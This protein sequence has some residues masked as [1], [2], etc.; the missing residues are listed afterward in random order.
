[1][2]TK[3]EKNTGGAKH[4]Y[5]RLKHVAAIDV[6]CYANLRSTLVMLID[7]Y[8]TVLDNMEKNKEKLAY[9]KGTNGGGSNLSMY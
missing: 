8:V 2:V 4:D 3:E 7:G 6:Q 5:H 9:P 1:M